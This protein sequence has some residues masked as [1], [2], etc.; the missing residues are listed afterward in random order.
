MPKQPKK[1]YQHKSSWGSIIYTVLAK[2]KKAMGRPQV[3]DSR[4]SLFLTLFPALSVPTPAVAVWPLV[5]F[6]DVPALEE[7]IGFWEVP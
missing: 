2:R 6:E 4:A 3:W 1:L 5:Q 7:S